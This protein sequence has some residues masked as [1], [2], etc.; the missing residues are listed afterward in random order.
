MELAGDED[1]L[2]VRIE[3]NVAGSDVP[4]G[5]ALPLGHIFL[6][7]TQV[8]EL[9]VPA[10]AGCGSYDIRRIILKIAWPVTV[11]TCFVLYYANESSINLF[12][13]LIFSTLT[14]TGSQ[15]LSLKKFVN[16]LTVTSFVQ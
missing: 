4:C 8:E 11:N 15:W 7:G 1:L 16:Y 3:E 14:S 13:F 2:A 6:A 5:Y 12:H 9:A 10:K